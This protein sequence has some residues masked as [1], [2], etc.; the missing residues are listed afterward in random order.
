MKKILLTG[1]SGYLE[2][3]LF[4]DLRNKFEV[5]GTYNRTRLYSEFIKLDT[6]NQNDVRE[7]IRKVQ[8]SIIIHAAANANR[9]WCQDHED[10]ARKIN[11]DATKYVVDAAK[12]IGSKIIFISSFAAN[13]PDY[14]YGYTKKQSEEIIKSTVDKYLIIR[15]SVIIGCSPQTETDNFFNHIIESID[16]QLN[17]FPAESTRRYQ[18]TYIGHLSEVISLSIERDINK[19]TTPVAVDEIKSRYDIAKDIIS[20]FDIKVTSFEDQQ[21]S[22]LITEDLGKLKELDLPV[23]QYKEMIKIVVDEIKHRGKF[24]L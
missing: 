15:P 5:V 2:A 17:E 3:R 23:Y 10:L 6:T 16:K 7:L 19:E 22:K 12:S 4:L 21:Y 18:P 1:A 11:I 9:K 24:K 14:F 13:N 20:T 8:P